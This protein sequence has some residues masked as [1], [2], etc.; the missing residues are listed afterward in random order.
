MVLLKMRGTKHDNSIRKFTIES[1]GIRMEAPFRGVSGILAG[2][3]APIVPGERVTRG[4]AT[5]RRARGS[6]QGNVRRAGTG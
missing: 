6:A 1:G 2:T 5:R 3:A 4:A